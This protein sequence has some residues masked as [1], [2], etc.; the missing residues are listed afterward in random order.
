MNSASHQVDVKAEID[1][2]AALLVD[3]T[4]NKT[5]RHTSSD[6]AGLVLFST[7]PQMLVR[8]TRQHNAT[9]TVVRCEVSSLKCC[10]YALQQSLT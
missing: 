9:T 3:V 7:S 4:Q 2:M 5:Q 8:S 6:I 1:S 10:L